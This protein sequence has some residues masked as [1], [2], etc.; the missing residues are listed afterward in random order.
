MHDFQKPLLAR[1]ISLKDGD[2]LVRAR[3]MVRVLWLLGCILFLGAALGAVFHLNVWLI[4]VLALSAGWVI[5]EVNALRHRLAQWPILREYI[6]WQRVT[7]D[8]R[9]AP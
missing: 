2:G 4:F 5:A 8:L 3:S 9:D 1:W 6:D 7:S